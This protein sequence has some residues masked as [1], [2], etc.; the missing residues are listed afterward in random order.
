M[1]SLLL[2]PAD[3]LWRPSEPTSLI[4]TLVELGFIGSCKEPGRLTRF[5]VGDRFLKL[6]MFLGCAPYVV[7]DAEADQPGQVAC[8]V[9]LLDYER[10][11]L[12]SRKGGPPARCRACRAVAE[13]PRVD[14]PEA[15]YQ[16]GS[17][18]KECQVADL[19]WR[20][21]AGY[22]RFFIQING[23]YP[24]EAIPSDRLMKALQVYA[25]C[26]WK[27]FYI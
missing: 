7:L 9:R 11:S 2:H 27:Y 25:Q 5:A 17:C 13:R 24:H 6:V 22:G 10:V 14:A 26:H 21:C 4:H 8:D 12:V 1:P 19:D 15:R 3:V 16:C 23:V 18:G 20:K